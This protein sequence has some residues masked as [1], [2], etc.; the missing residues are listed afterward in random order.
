M[1]LRQLGNRLVIVKL[2]INAMKIYKPY[3]WQKLSESIRA[4]FVDYHPLING[5]EESHDQLKFVVMFEKIVLLHTSKYSYKITIEIKSA[6]CVLITMDNF[7]LF[8]QYFEDFLRMKS[9]ELFLQ[10]KSCR[11]KIIEPNWIFT[12]DL[13]PLF[14]E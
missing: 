11:K 8:V 10:R 5:F 3:L 13:I 12:V 14:S 4:T 9:Q 6:V 7:N 2:F 1:L